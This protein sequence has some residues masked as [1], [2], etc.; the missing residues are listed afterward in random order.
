MS[1]KALGGRLLERQNS[2]VIIVQ[3]QTARVT[4]EMRLAEV[5]VE[6]SVVFE[7]GVFQFVRSDV[8]RLLED[9]ECLVFVEQT[10]GQEVAYLQNEAFRF[11][12]QR[13]LGFVDLAVEQYNLSF[14]RKAG[15]QLAETF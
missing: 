12:E 5:I 14:G 10:H 2:D 13:G 4:F 7:F 6:E 9:P 3:A 1:G 8:E 11:L 15:K